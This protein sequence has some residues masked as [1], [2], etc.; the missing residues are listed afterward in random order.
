MNFEGSI[1][2][3]GAASTPSIAIDQS[4][5]ELIVHES[6]M[7]ECLPLAPQVSGTKW[8]AINTASGMDWHS[9]KE[10][11]QSFQKLVVGLTES[12]KKHIS[13]DN[14]SEPLVFNEFSFRKYP[15]NS[16]KSY[17]IS[18]HRDDEKYINVIVV[19]ILKGE[20]GFFVCRDKNDIGQEVP[21]SIGRPIIMRGNNFAGI[22]DRPYHYVK[23]TNSERISFTLRQR[24]NKI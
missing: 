18:A 6:E 15:A 14:F 1:K 7:I 8:G 16:T 12:I 13:E 21:T 20:P 5:L 2:T 3:L 11:P 19:C 22:K 9:I 17:S 24:N 23:S 4:I 10:L